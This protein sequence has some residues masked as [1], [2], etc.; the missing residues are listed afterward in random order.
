MPAEPKDP[1]L[2]DKG[3]NLTAQGV[4]RLRAIAGALQYV[5]SST[6]PDLARDVPNIG[7][8]AKIGD[9]AKL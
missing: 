7:S 2:R 4:T 6:R 5:S 1:D 3:G 9:N 8:R